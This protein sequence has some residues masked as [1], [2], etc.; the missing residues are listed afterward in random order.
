M[1]ILDK[2]SER[3]YEIIIT[4]PFNAESYS[5]IYTDMT[6]TFIDMRLDSILSNFTIDSNM[7]YNAEINSY[8][9]HLNESLNIE[10]YRIFE[11][12]FLIPQLEHVME[13]FDFDRIIDITVILEKLESK[14]GIIIEE[15][16]LEEHWKARHNIE[17]PRVVLT[18]L[19][20]ICSHYLRI[21]RFKDIKN[22]TSQFRN[23]NE[24]LD[25]LI[26]LYAW[27][28][29]NT[30]NEN[31]TLEKLIYKHESNIISALIPTHTNVKMQN[32]IHTVYKFKNKYSEIE[33]LLE[34]AQDNDIWKLSRINSNFEFIDKS[35]KETVKISKNKLDLLETIKKQSNLLH[36]YHI[37][38]VGS[39]A[40]IIGKPRYIDDRFNVNDLPFVIEKCYNS[41]INASE[42]AKWDRYWINLG[43][44]YIHNELNTS[45]FINHEKDKE[46]LNLKSA[47]PKQ[48]RTH[49]KPTELFSD[50]SNLEWKDITITIYFYDILKLSVEAKGISTRIKDAKTFGLSNKI[51]R[52]KN[53]MLTILEDFSINDN[54]LPEIP[55]IKD[56][57]NSKKELMKNYTYEETKLM[58]IKSNPDKI[59][60]ARVNQLRGI[61]RNLFTF[62]NK[63]IINDKFPVAK[64]DFNGKEYKNYKIKFNLIIKR[65]PKQK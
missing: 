20:K 59:L 47:K 65:F 41:W 13:W 36:D 11:L 44:K 57:L 10:K 52:E 3:I 22:I 12:F 32:F 43:A 51:D 30:D 45:I 6:T 24:T 31:M 28:I 61:L 5:E 15:S 4:K 40:V 35:S 46:I 29:I 9:D 8:I 18:K 50:L 55:D 38:P 48:E 56:F 60:K 39:D 19:K 37:K 64:W 42:V 63:L 7:S 34:Y 23:K 49:I 33:N 21:S 26:P 58:L 53:Q 62:N 2:L 16:Q 17:L 27:K 14:Y 25:H 1:K 54:T